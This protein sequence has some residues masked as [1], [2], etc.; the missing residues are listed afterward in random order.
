[1]PVWRARPLCVTRYHAFMLGRVHWVGR[2]PPRNWRPDLHHAWDVRVPADDPQIVVA[3]GPLTLSRAQATPRVAVGMAS[4]RAVLA[5]TGAERHAA[6]RA[7]R[8]FAYQ[9]P[10][11]R[12]LP[13]GRVVDRAHGLLPRDFGPRLRLRV[14]R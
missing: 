10:W 1:M 9:L 6:L 7:V 4:R 2:H 3:I 5:G 14:A 12:E 11:I 8:W 13:L